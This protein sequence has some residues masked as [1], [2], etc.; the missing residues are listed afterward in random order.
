M[1]REN[2]PPIPEDKLKTWEGSNHVASAGSYF[3]HRAVAHYYFGEH[4]EAEACLA[5]VRT[6]LHG[7]TDNVLKRQ[8]YV[9]QV[10]NALKLHEREPG[11]AEEAALFAKIRPMI[12]RVETWAELGPLLKPYMALL[13]AEL[14]RVT[15]DL[16]EARGLFLDAIDAAHGQ[17]YTFLEGYLHECLAELLLNAGQRSVGIYFAEAARLYRKCHAGRK[18]ISLVERRSEYFEEGE[19]AYQRAE[20]EPAAY[21]LPNLDVDYL[22]K[23]AF[24]ISAEMEQEALMKKIMKVVIE[25]SGA[26]DGY[27]LIED[28]GPLIVRAESHIVEKQ[29]PRTLDRRLED[30]Q[31]IC[32]V[33]VR[34]V[35]RTGERVI[36]GNACQEGAFKDN[37]EV[38]ERQLRSVLCLP[39]VKQ[40][41]RIGIL[42]LENSLVD[43]AFTAERT[44]M[45]ELLASQAAIS[46]E[47]AGL[48]NDMVKAEEEVRKSLRE[49]EVLL[50]EVHHRVKNNLQIVSSLLNLQM[51]YIHNE[52]A[53]DLFKESQNRII[54]MAL[55]HE[56]LYESESLAGIGVA[57]YIQSLTDNLFRSYG[58]PRAVRMEIDVADI[59]LD[60]DTVIPCALII[61]ELVS[62]SLKHAFPDSWR[63]T[64]GAG[65]IRIDFH[66]DADNR[67]A[68][69]VTDNGVG[70]PAGF[71][72]QHCESLGLK[73]VGVLV[74]QLRGVLHRKPGAGAGFTITFEAPQ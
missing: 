71:D 43:S 3:V 68:L 5:R 50:K 30:V 40:S 8:W 23:S 65:E 58:A 31:G 53:A 42:Y 56:K 34:Y 32:K 33:I 73:L 44:Q 38:Q 47:N 51:P 69:T 15:G 35:T 62:N 22:M 25:C 67:F 19:E 74:K 57:E 46:L 14:A 52:Q 24:A 54:S 16:K 36:L 48:V 29:T 45:T 49:K 17:N 63:Q 18:E 59:T 28:R 26:Q 39:V 10:L 61:N 70:L 13:D 4:D 60:I 9:F 2:A 37:P 72:V 1:K 27:L 12:K 21:T 66:R 7:L 41:K 55:I 20:A 64:G 6:Y 11:F